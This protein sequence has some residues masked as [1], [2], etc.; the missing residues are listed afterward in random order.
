MGART[1]GWA[2]LLAVAVAIPFVAAN[3]DICQNS[4]HR[5]VA[6]A[7]GVDVQQTTRDCYGSTGSQKLDRYDVNV[8]TPEGRHNV[9]YTSETET[10]T[11]QPSWCRFP[12]AGSARCSQ[13]KVSV[14][15]QT[16]LTGRYRE[17]GDASWCEYS[18]VVQRPEIQLSD[19]T[20]RNDHCT[21]YVTMLP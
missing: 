17:N 1:G 21:D 6:S 2:L 9:T 19:G 10:G 3:P 7:P 20:T 14:D 5:Q 18:V 15:D 11:W 16:N 12:P 13:A 8:T 4:G